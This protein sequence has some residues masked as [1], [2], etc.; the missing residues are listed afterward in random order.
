[1]DIILHPSEIA[2][3]GSLHPLVG[4]RSPASF[5]PQRRTFHKMQYNT[6]CDFVDYAE[7]A[8]EL[9][10]DQVLVKVKNIPRS[11]KPESLNCFHIEGHKVVEGH[12]LT[13]FTA[14]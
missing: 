4:A 2:Q 13:A 14:K 5:S 11:R 7:V 6:T 9:E 8:M 10:L 12:T 1:M 3:S